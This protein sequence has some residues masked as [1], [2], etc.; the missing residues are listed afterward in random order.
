M[1]TAK[2]IDLEAAL[3]RATLDASLE[4]LSEK[5][6]IVP[7]TQFS[8]ERNKQNVAH[9]SDSS[10]NEDMGITPSSYDIHNWSKRPVREHPVHESFSDD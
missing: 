10:F 2:S 7:Q 1:V 6:D 9:R 5:R 4:D 8:S 3:A